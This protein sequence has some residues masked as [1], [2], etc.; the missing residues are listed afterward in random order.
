MLTLVTSTLALA[1]LGA[2]ITVQQEAQSMIGWYVVNYYR[3]VPDWAYIFRF[4][5]IIFSGWKSR[6]ILE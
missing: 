4:F 5:K 6:L 3:A 2:V 1:A